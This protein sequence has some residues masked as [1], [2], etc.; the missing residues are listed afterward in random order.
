MRDRAARVA[1][2][3]SGTGNLHNVWRAC[4]HVGL[5]SHITANPADVLSAAAVILPG[6][7]AMPESMHA[8]RESGLADALRTVATR[9]TPLLG[10][11]LG[12]QMLMAH[13]TEFTSHDGLGIFPGRVERFPTRDLDGNV[14]R[15]PHIGWTPIAAPDDRTDAWDDTLLSTT[16]AGT[17]MYFVHSYR[18]IPDDTGIV[19]ATAGYRGVEFVA[20]VARDNIF[21]CQFHPERSGPAGLEIYRQFAARVAASTAETV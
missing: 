9:G 14:L 19:A 5:D 21:A 16:P 10:V 1:I 15:V 18:V 3:D 8:L 4:A 20:A 2:V 12:L 6:V 17:S 11:C 7:G 13:G